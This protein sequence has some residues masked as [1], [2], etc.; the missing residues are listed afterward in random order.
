LVAFGS[1]ASATGNDA[2][3]EYFIEITRRLCASGF[4]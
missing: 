2:D 3:R 4:R 1:R